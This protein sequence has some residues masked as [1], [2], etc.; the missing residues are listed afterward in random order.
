M[1]GKREAKSK[2]EKERYKH[3]TAEFQRIARRNKKAFLSDQCKEIEENKRMGK[4]RDLFE[5]IRD[6]KGTFHAKMVTIKDRNG[7]DLTEAEDKKRWQ[8][9]T[10]ELYKKYLH[11]PDNHDGMIT[12]LEP[13]ILECEVK[14]ALGSIT[15]NKA[16]RGDGIPVE[17]FQILKD[18]AVKVLH[19]ICQQIWKTAVATGLEKISFHSNP[20]ERQ[21]QRMLKLLHNCTRH[22]LEK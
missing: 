18:D 11:D 6:T 12:H 16:S 22:T 7:M 19:S 15:M 2:G 10:E 1:A 4:T 5:K 9:Y 17:L 20:K 21:C 13:D 3:L 14:W 8:E